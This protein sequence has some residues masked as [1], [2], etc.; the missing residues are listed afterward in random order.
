MSKKMKAAVVYVSIIA[1]MLTQLIY[2]NAENTARSLE[3]Q[4]R[5]SNSVILFIGSNKAYNNNIMTYIDA[6]NPGVKPVISGGR[7][8]VP[9]RF[10]SESLG[11]SVGWDQKTKTVTLSSADMTIKLV[12][13]SKVLE[14]NGVNKEMDVAA[15][16]MNGRTLVPLR[17]ISE[18]LGRTVFYDK[19]LIVISEDEV[20]NKDS[21]GS[22]VTEVIGWFGNKDADVNELAKSVVLVTCYDEFGLKSLQGSGFFVSN[23]LVVTNKHVVEEASKIEITLDNDEVYPVYSVA[24]HESLDLAIL[25]LD[26][27]IDVTPLELGTWSSIKRGDDITAI[28]SPE[29]FK[30]TISKGIVSGLREENGI[31]YVQITA[32]IT[33]GSSGGPLFN[34]SGQVLG[35]NTMGQQEG[36]LFFSISSDHV[37][38]WLSKVA[39]SDFRILGI[40]TAPTSS[41]LSTDDTEYL[42]EAKEFL[43]YVFDLM[44]ENDAEGYI[45]TM[46]VEPTETQKQEIYDLFESLSQVE[47]ECFLE[48]ARKS[49]KEEI[50][51][52][53]NRTNTIMSN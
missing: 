44:E 53:I 14:V 33:H 2:V 51:D 15:A 9:V 40:P 22:L 43:N 24:I 4:E 20:L 1:I 46:Y 6:G 41:P 28:G 39:D 35:V 27:A 8:L 50:P 42:E 12:I 25:K 13:G 45:N 38:D 49:M 23:N 32:P 17:A 30:N 10:I 36:S 3:A 11:L 26:Q 19:G 21:D 31:K 47:F 29:G 5:T 37:R 7:T 52:N 18:A 34:K 48:A 16:I